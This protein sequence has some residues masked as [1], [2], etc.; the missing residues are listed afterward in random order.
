MHNT[1]YKICMCIILL[2]LL[3]S[4]RSAPGPDR[5]MGL[6]V[7]A[8]TRTHAHAGPRTKDGWTDT[9]THSNAGTWPCRT[10]H[11]RASGRRWPHLPYQQRDGRRGSE[12]GSVRLCV[13]VGGW[14]WVCV[15]A[16][17]SVCLPPPPFPLKERPSSSLRGVSA[18]DP[19]LLQP[20]YS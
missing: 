3:L 7:R 19:L 18:G 12:R 8:R 15:C 5:C 6:R 11:S 1:T 2:T 13:C 10:C 16:R 9:R 4:L 14:V 20:S 17:A